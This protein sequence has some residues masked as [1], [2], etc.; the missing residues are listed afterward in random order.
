MRLRSLVLPAF[1]PALLWLG[2]RAAPG[3]PKAVHIVSDCDSAGNPAVHPSAPVHMKH[4][5]WVVWDEPAHKAS[6]WTIAPKNEKKWP[7][8][9]PITGN[10]KHPANSGKPA[11]STPANDTVG[12]NVTIECKD[13]TTQHIDPIIIIGQ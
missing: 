11:A 2:S 6:S 1:F 8:P 4:Q 13:G 5:D 10:Q 7:F 9:N 12:Y 3:K